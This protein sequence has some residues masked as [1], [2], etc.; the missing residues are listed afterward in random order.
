APSSPFS[1]D[2]SQGCPPYDP[3]K[4]KQ[5]LQDAGVPVPFPIKVQVT[6]SPD[7]LRYAQAL[8][9]SAADGGFALT[10]AP[11]E[12]STLLDVQSHGSFEALLLGWSGRVDP[13]G[14]MYNFLATGGGNNYSGYSNPA[15]DKLLTDAS[16]STDQAA[17]A[18]LY[19]K[20][21]QQVQ[22]DNPIIYLY[23]IHSLTAYS[24]KVAGVETFADGVVH[25]SNA[26]FVKK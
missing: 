10:I 18:A 5:M 12:Y 23:R 11:V 7:S 25:L 22:A 8:Q 16:A 19:G 1:S 2:A 3:A 17:R 15:V 13:H 9:A 21:V 20:A 26:A 24:N 4:A 14:N 6:N